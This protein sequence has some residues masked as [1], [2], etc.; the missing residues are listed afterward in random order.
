M[1]DYSDK[2]FW[3][4]TYGGYDPSPSLQGDIKVDIAI[5]GAGF[6][7]AFHARQSEQKQAADSCKLISDLA[8]LKE[9]NIISDE[10]FASKKNE[11]LS[12]L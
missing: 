3:L 12:R 10:E 5:I 7:E 9:Q 11:L 2:S 1:K 4:A 6:T 8:E